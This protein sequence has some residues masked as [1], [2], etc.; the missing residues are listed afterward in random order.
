MHFVCA[1]NDRSTICVD[2]IIQN[3]LAVYKLEK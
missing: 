3:Y 1:K 2:L